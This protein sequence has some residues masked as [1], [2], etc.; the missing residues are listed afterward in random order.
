[1]L[2]GH[3]AEMSGLDHVWL[4]YGLRHDVAPDVRFGGANLRMVKDLGQTVRWAALGW[5]RGGWWARLWLAA[6]P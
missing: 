6:G 5:V 3:A 1:M 2:T 4:T